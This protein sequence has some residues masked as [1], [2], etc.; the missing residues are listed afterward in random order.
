MLIGRRVYYDTLSGDMLVDTGERN[1]EVRKTTIERDIEVYS[2]LSERN[3]ETFDVIELEYGQYAQD[4]A[5]SI[6]YR[7]NPET[8]TLEFSYPDP[9]N[10]EVPQPF[11]KSL[12]V[13]IE[14]TKQAL[15][16]LSLFIAGGM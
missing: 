16:E 9:S 1:G 4:F 2:K 6:D 5:E 3:R 15:A 11:V 12:S 13:E 10:P 14:E 8:K 7:V